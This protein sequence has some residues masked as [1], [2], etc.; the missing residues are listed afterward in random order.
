VLKHSRASEARLRLSWNQPDLEISV[1]DTG[2]GFDPA[3]PS[4][5]NGLANQQA[6]LKRIGGTIELA[7]HAGDG[8][9]IVF[10]VKLDGG[11]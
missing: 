9:R 1:E 6:R 8:T 5:G 2:C 7:S 4:Q 11:G 3:V 10:G